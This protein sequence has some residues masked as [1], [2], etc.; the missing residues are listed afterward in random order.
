MRTIRLVL[1]LYRFEV[2]V[3]S[4]SLVVL[5]LATVYVADR[6]A[7]L[8]A[9]IAT[10][11]DPVR[12]TLLKE[13]QAR[14]AQQASM[15]PL[16]GIVL[17]IFA[18]VIFGVPIVAREVE[19]G[20]ATLP[21]TMS[22]SRHGWFLR[23]IVIVGGVLAAISILP[24]ITL[25]LLFGAVHPET[26]LN[27]SFV[28]AE[29]RGPIIA[30]RALATFAVASLAGALMGK[31][32]P[33]VLLAI[34]SCAGLL[35]GLQLAN[36]TWLRAEAVPLPVAVSQDDAFIVDV[37]FELPERSNWS[38][39]IQ[40]GQTSMIPIGTPRRPTRRATSAWRRSSHPR[41]APAR[42]A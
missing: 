25:E 3:L 16:L 32:L 40:P 1:K 12:C 30:A 11:Q 5:S 38:T 22:P 37:G 8:P 28:A 23:R 41:S 18:G 21:W 31:S 27:H 15:F 34:A 20:T 24:A 39:G 42:S 26:N 13:D 35:I 2:V 19:R 6:L 9:A 14:L 36:A 7:A 17:P 10:C 4:L 29:S 33:G